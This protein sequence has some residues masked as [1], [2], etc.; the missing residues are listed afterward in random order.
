MSTSL[1]SESDALV[2][3]NIPAAVPTSSWHY[4]V[5]GMM[6]LIVYDF[7]LQSLGFFTNSFGSSFGSQSHIV[8][9]VAANVVQVCAIFM[10]SKVPVSHGIVVSCIGLAIV[11]VLFPILAHTQ[12]LIDGL[13]LS[14]GLG[15]FCAILQSIGSASAGNSSADAIV[16]FYMGQSV[17]G[18]L[19]WPMIEG[20][21]A[22]FRCLGSGTVSEA[23]IR[24][25]Y[26]VMTFVA[27]LSLVFLPYYFFGMPRGVA[28]GSYNISSIWVTFKSMWQWALCAWL[29]FVTTFAVYPQLPLTWTASHPDIYPAGEFFYG[30]ML[31]YIAIFFDILG[32]NLPGVSMS[33][34]LAVKVSV[35]LRIFFI[36][37]L[38]LFC[39]DNDIWRIAACIVLAVSGSFLL[40]MVLQFGCTPPS[41]KEF[42]AE[43]AGY[44]L[45][46]AL[47]NG[48]VVG[49]SLS[50]GVSQTYGIIQVFKNTAEH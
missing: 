25:T 34:K 23:D 1:D 27:I 47:C 39:P 9:A 29:L 43:V 31:I 22:I 13:I 8:Y 14:C 16:Y 6:S 12:K 24:T 18:L 32:M 3:K 48:I 49:S 10:G 28:P 42:S 4:L 5:F 38:F 15:F 26:T 7:F 30:N 17:A 50:W 33:S 21:N 41:S 44:I 2:P 40:S 45:S 46:F 35:G 19:P 37:I 20:L 11:S 36:P